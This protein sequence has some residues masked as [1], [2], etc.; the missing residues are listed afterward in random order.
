[1]KRQRELKDTSTGVILEGFAE[2]ITPSSVTML[3]RMKSKFCLYQ[4]QDSLLLD[5]AV[6]LHRFCPCLP[7]CLCLCPGS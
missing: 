4:Y 6:T 1:M 2:D 3:H 5:V 7:P